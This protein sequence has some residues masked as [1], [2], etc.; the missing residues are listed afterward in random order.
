M[1]T[2]Y[3]FKFCWLECSFST[4]EIHPYR[5]FSAVPLTVREGDESHSG[6]PWVFPQPFPFSEVSVTAWHDT[7]VVYHC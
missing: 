1:P 6:H 4:N 2:A 5:S 3:A 7:M